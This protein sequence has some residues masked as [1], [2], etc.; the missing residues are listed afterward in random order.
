MALPQTVIYYT[1][2]DWLKERAGYSSTDV[3]HLTT[4]QRLSSRDALPAVIGGASRVFAVTAISPIEMVRTRMQS[5]RMSPGAW[6]EENL[7]TTKQV[8]CDAVNDGLS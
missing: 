1:L 7:R 2:N 8:S 4:N 3:N 5:V 6:L